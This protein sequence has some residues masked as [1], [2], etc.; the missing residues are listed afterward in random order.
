MKK[1][2]TVTLILLV[3]LSGCSRQGNVTLQEGVIS[4]KGM[5][6]GAVLS[7][8]YD[9][10][11]EVGIWLYSQGGISAAIAVLPAG[12]FAHPEKPMK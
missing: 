12:Q 5:H 10:V 3:L 2:I 8:Y 1:L 4:P 7:Y 11:H 9:E 6:N